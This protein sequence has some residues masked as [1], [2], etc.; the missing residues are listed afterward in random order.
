MIPLFFATG[1]HNYAKWMTLYLMNLLNMDE[2]H[3][4]LRNKFESDALT[5]GRS[6]RK[7]S[8]NEVDLTLEQTI[9]ADAASR[10][11]GISAFTQSINARKYWNLLHSARSKIVGAM[12][13]KVGLMSIEETSQELKK[14]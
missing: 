7:F 1:H 2:M 5:I 10:L 11:T 13:E 12:M 3:P 6:S 8:R 14:Y 4:G 9:N